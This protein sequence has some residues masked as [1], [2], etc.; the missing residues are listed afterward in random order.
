MRVRNQFNETVNLFLSHRISSVGNEILPP[1]EKQI[2]EFH[3][4]MNFDIILL[5][6]AQNE[7]RI[8]CKVNHLMFF[9]Y[10]SQCLSRL[11]G[12]YALQ[13]YMPL[14]SKWLRWNFEMP[15]STLVWVRPT[16]DIVFLLNYEKKLL[17]ALWMADLQTKWGDERQERKN[18]NCSN[19]TRRNYNYSSNCF[20]FRRN[21]NIFRS[22]T[23]GR[24]AYTVPH[25]QCQMSDPL[26]ILF[27]FW[28]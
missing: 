19:L 26:M 20:M 6:G 18:N 17:I 14:N 10:F 21:W 28:K 27:G 4:S 9:F 22:D 25:C 23:I 3:L 2:E 7:Y 12:K 16:E 11:L 5:D 15:W 1:A 8:V 24:T 13:S